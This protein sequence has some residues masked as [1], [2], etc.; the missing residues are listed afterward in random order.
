M[1]PAD[2]LAHYLRGLLPA[3]S[4]NIQLKATNNLA[5][6]QQEAVRIETI[7]RHANKKPHPSN[8]T[9]RQAFHPTTTLSPNA[10]TPPPP[11]AFRLW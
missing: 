2:E 1:S 3:I 10:S 8:L 5:E 6:A 9:Q 11:P 7:L 4:V